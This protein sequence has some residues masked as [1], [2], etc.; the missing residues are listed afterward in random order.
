MKHLLKAEPVALVHLSGHN[1]ITPEMPFGKRV[2][3]EFE[4]FNKTHSVVLKIQTNLFEK[5]ALVRY[6]DK[7]GVECVERPRISTYKGTFSNGG[8]IRVVV[9]E[10]DVVQAMWLEREDREIWLLTPVTYYETILP[11]V[12][13]HF[14]ER[15][16]KMLAHRL[17]E[18]ELRH[19]LLQV[20]K[21]PG[22]LSNGLVNSSGPYG[23]MAGC[24]STMQRVPIAFAL[25]TGYTKRLSGLG[26]TN[27]ST[28]A[29]VRRA[30]LDIQFQMNVINVLFVD[31]I[32]VFLTLGEIVVRT[33]TGGEAWNQEPL[34]AAV[35]DGT[36]ASMLANGCP[37]SRQ[38]TDTDTGA[39][40]SALKD[41]RLALP[42][43]RRYALW[44]LMTACFPPPGVVGLAYIGTTCSSIA[45]GWSSIKNEGTYMTVAHEIGHNFGAAHTFDTGG[46]MSYDPLGTKE[47]KFTGNNSV[48]ICSHV[49]SVKGICYNTMTA[50]CG[51]YVVEA[52]EECDDP[53]ACCNQSTCTLITGA[54][55]SPGIDP[56]CCTALC[57]FIPTYVG[58]IEA[59]GMGQGYCSNGICHLS[60]LGS[61]YGNIQGCNAPTSNACKEYVRPVSGGACNQ[62]DATY[63]L[64]GYNM[65]DGSVCNAL[66][67]KTCLNGLCVTPASPQVLGEG[68]TG[69]TVV[70][71]QNPL[72]DEILYRGTM[73]MI[74][75][76]T[77]PSPPD[78]DPVT[79]RLS[80]GSVLSQGGSL[81]HARFEWNVQASPGNYTVS[82]ET[83][84]GVGVSGVFRVEPL[85]DI[86]W[87][88][89]LQ[90][91]VV[92]AGEATILS[93]TNVGSAKDAAISLS[94][95]DEGNVTMQELGSPPNTGTF[96]WVPSST[97]PPTRARVALRY[98]PA[99]SANV[100]TYT[101]LF[102][103]SPST[104]A[105]L[106]FVHPVGEGGVQVGVS[107]SLAWTSPAGQVSLSWR[108]QTSP[109][110]QWTRLFEKRT[111]NHVEW[112]PETAG[113]GFQ[114]QLCLQDGDCLV[115]NAFAIS[116]RQP[117]V[118]IESVFNGQDGAL[119]VRG[120]NATFVVSASD[121]NDTFALQI[122]D[123]HGV[124]VYTLLTDAPVGTTTLFIPHTV[125][126]PDFFSCFLI[127]TSN[128][129]GVRDTFPTPFS[130]LSQGHNDLPRE[131]ASI[132]MTNPLNDTE[133]I[134]HSNL[135]ITWTGVWLLCVRILLHDLQHNV[136]T[137]VGNVSN[138]GFFM[139][140]VPPL[141]DDQG[142]RYTLQLQS[143]DVSTR[144]VFLRNAPRRGPPTLS[145]VKN[146]STVTEGETVIVEYVSSNVV[147]PIRL[148]L[149]T[150]S[151]GVCHVITTTAPTN[152]SISIPFIYSFSKPTHDAFYVLSS[153]GV[154]AQ[155]NPFTVFGRPG[156]SN[157]R[158]SA[159]LFKGMTHPSPHPTPLIPVPLP[160]QPRTHTE[161]SPAP[162]PRPRA[163][164]GPQVHVPGGSRGARVAGPPGR[165]W[166]PSP[167]Q[168][169]S[170]RW[171]AL[172]PPPLRK[173]KEALPGQPRPLADLTDAR[174]ARLLVFLTESLPSSLPSLPSTGPLRAL[175]RAT[176]PSPTRRKE[177]CALSSF[178]SPTRRK[179]KC[180]LSSF[181]L[182]PDHNTMTADRARPSRTRRCI[183]G[184]LLA[185]VGMAVAVALIFTAG[186]AGQKKDK[187]AVTSGGP[188]PPWT[189]PWTSRTPSTA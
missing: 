46:L 171:A 128:T 146:I 57:K 61:A 1:A 162:G 117:F 140:R 64:S 12:A 6:N 45:A 138:T 130:I 3:L 48:Q 177:K 168:G 72:P 65:K 132:V 13:A 53:S 112:I 114:L 22:V 77:S 115:S 37:L 152:G 107:Y 95:V 20:L 31:M 60:R 29:A 179:E 10:D 83:A 35:L 85:P 99:T 92:Y 166:A 5:D 148:E 147:N 55:C 69:T 187:A 79:L 91:D 86:R 185:A 36:P 155:S 80:D 151:F 33:R 103:I 63:G 173:K 34:N 180:A 75:W 122:A 89:P 154:C 163:S 123:R 116:M 23:I 7:D 18:S 184:G 17:G 150:K 100:T 32:N 84:T 165:A 96:T 164:R 50:R 133:V 87:T 2:K 76:S 189:P 158:T 104:S 44:H 124:L 183:Y 41:W 141:S 126:P 67:D 120:R 62:I 28:M 68:A 58:C 73:A 111:E 16:G 149:W 21:M 127:A 182:T 181:L 121:M 54:M 40:L 136:T 145:V 134:S 70:V 156:L 59:G 170:H 169:H 129:Y 39:V 119:L 118:K 52:G 4:A 78:S 135:R 102:Q 186:G 161:S 24:P 106:A 167:P 93:W 97:L 42:P 25:D 159:T 30:S 90:G 157:L 105:V 9:H 26:T 160:T 188:S 88:Y 110:S 176:T 38:N 43:N 8:W 94:V 113:V 71:V 51:N 19:R 142:H 139:W 153:P 11:E 56:Q 81:D 108:Q 137:Q 178:P 109:E 172:P 144:P 49:M 47:F 27:I 143:G 15:G 98:S 82:V 125:P 14:K 174:M 131:P 101:P 175:G 66:L 74:Q